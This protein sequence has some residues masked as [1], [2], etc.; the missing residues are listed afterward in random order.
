M[1]ISIEF[2]NQIECAKL[3]QSLVR[4]SFLTAPSANIHIPIT[5]SACT[6][7]QFGLLLA[8][9]LCFACEVTAQNLKRLT[10]LPAQLVEVSGMW[11]AGPDSIWWLNDGG[12][13]SALYLTDARGKLRKSLSLPL[14]NRD[15]EEL[16][17]DDQG[18]LYIGDFGNNN[19]NRN[20]LRIYKLHLA[21]M[22]LDSI[23]FAYPDQRAFPPGTPNEMHFDCEAMVWH[24]NS[25]HLFS[26]CHYAG[27]NFQSTYYKM[28]DKAGLQIPQKIAQI[29]LPRQVI[30]G[31]AL[32]PDKKQIAFTSYLY[33][34]RGRIYLGK[35][36][37]RVFA[38]PQLQTGKPVLMKK[39]RLR[40]FITA[41]QVESVGFYRENTILVASEKT[42]VQRQKMKRV[43]R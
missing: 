7:K 21:T 16:T 14:P 4:S 25:L 8:F 12:N 6:M 13:A 41:R 36:Y 20:D 37:L 26:K 27:T 11:I 33:K 9:F 39:R 23:W 29:D 2:R 40:G 10:T 30:T 32:S 3:T 5:L 42:P 28:P 43:R 38:W 1:Q 17:G 19:N 18:N 15:W 35:S 31:A 22:Q 34:K 24:E